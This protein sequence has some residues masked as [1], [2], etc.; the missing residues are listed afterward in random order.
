MADAFSNNSASKG[1]AKGANESLH[2]TSEP[3]QKAQAVADA[4]NRLLDSLGQRCVKGNEIYDYF[5]VGVIGYNSEVTS[6]L[7]G[8]A[9]DNAIAPIGKIYENPSELEKR[10]QKLPDGMGGLVEVYNDFPIWFKPIAS[11]GTA[12]CSVFALARILL[13]DWIEKHPNSYP[14]TIIN[15]TD[16]ESTDGDPTEEAINLKKLNT[17]DGSVLL[18]NIHLSAEYTQPVSFPN[19]AEVLSDPYAR[20][21]FDLSSPLPYAAQKAAEKE[22]YKITP[23]ARAFMFNADP[24]KLIQFLDIGTRTENLR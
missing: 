8:L 20:L 9:G 17:S 21:M 7:N 5:D 6:A 13:E 14:P 10:A 2:K 11:G 1:T 3:I 4:V 16:G 19:T 12:M 23:D 24:V 22:G 18:Y 15:I